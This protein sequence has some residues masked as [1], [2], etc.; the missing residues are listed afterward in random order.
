[1]MAST[2]RHDVYTSEF[3]FVRHPEPAKDLSGGRISR[4]RVS[5]AFVLSEKFRL[6]FSSYSGMTTHTYFVYILSSRTRVLYIGVT[7]D[8]RRR[9]DQ[10]RS[11]TG[12]DFTRRYRVCRLVYVENFSSVLEAIQR[13]KQLKG[14]VRRRKVELIESLNP[15]WADLAESL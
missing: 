9:L 13:E 5:A 4:C 2:P 11:G 7:N 1:M 6:A 14:W 12:S 15:S 3:P 8:L 10:H